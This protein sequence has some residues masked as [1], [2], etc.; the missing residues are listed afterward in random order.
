[1]TYC[2]GTGGA[3]NSE[4]GIGT[5]KGFAI[6]PSLERLEP[7]VYVTKEVVCPGTDHAT[8]NRLGRLLSGGFRTI[9]E[10]LT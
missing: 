10:H 4:G 3:P 6:H 7:K 9:F 1:M 8:Y 2:T 5:L